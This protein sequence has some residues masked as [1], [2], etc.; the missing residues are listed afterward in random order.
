MRMDFSFGRSGS[1]RQRDD[2]A[3]ARIL[4]LADLH[5]ADAPAR[6]A[7]RPIVRVDTDN[8]HQA[9]ARC[10][11]SATLPAERAGQRLQFRTFDDFHP[12]LL[13]GNA[14]LFGRLTDLR[15]RLRHPD[16]FAAA[17]AE[18]RAETAPEAAPQPAPARAERDDVPATL[19]RLLGQSA[20]KTP[21]RGQ[22]RA[23]SIVDNL[24]RQ[25]VAPYIVAA[26]DPR[27]PELV[28]AVDG[29]MGDVMRGIL[30]DP[31]FQEVEATW[32]GI[33]WLASSLELGERLELHVLHVTRGELSRGAGAG[34]DLYQRLI[35]QEAQTSGGLRPSAIVGAYRFE[36]T[37]ED[38]ALLESMGALARAVDAPFVAECGA[39]LLGARS[40]AQ[41]PD[42]RDWTALETGIEARWQAL[43]AGHAGPYLG[44]VLP[45][46][47]L[48]LPY[49]RK[50]DPIETFAFEELPPDADHEAF[51]WG[52]AAFACALVIARELDAE[53]EPS[54]AGSI[55]GLPAFTFDT[56]EGP[57]L[58]PCAEV[59]LTERAV[60]AVLAR[61]IMPLVSVKGTDA[62]RF[63]RL[64]SIADPPTAL[65]T[66][67]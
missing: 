9:L 50:A 67:R 6:V 20:D 64:Q 41:Q 36:A 40:V 33:H 16:T 14:P 35:D 45:R 62:V 29:A 1:S 65:L 25:A 31:G 37:A 66:N 51:L 53:E 47:L 54:D 27:V 44:L 34:S 12:D 4:I 10:A 7:D 52:N 15:K 46:I 43:R 32:R 8:I 61:G 48:R 24:V 21:S 18:L 57:R 49:G 42:P 55:A 63:V 23:D 19:E 22:P 38:L 28:S 11:P 17:A 60:G 58:Q 2:G 3:P 39:S 56:A 26:A 59:C 13:I 30:H 5:A